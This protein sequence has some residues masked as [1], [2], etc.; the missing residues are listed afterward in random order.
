MTVPAGKTP[1]SGP[2]A[3]AVSE[4][5]RVV[6]ARRRCTAKQLAEGTGISANYLGKRLRDEA[7]FTMN[8]IEAICKAL[9]ENLWSFLR[10]LIDAAEAQQRE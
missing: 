4:E 2:F 6:M 10:S 1:E 3:R 8:D 7:P 5:I 9:G